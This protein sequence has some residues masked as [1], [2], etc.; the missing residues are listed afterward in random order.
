MAYPK[1]KML[2]AGE[3]TDGTSGKSE[4]VICPANGDELGALPHAS[5][6]DLDTALDSSLIGFY[7]WRKMTPLSRQ[8]VLEKGCW[9][10]VSKK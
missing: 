9:M 3:W 7:Q 8:V 2:I 4:P 10:I 5:S 1:L 6:I